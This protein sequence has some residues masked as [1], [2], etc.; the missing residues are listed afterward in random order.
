MESILQQAL[1][2]CI[3]QNDQNVILEVTVKLVNRDGAWW[4]VPDQALLH[5]LSGLA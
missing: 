5:A 4:V 3:S 2:Q 1:Q